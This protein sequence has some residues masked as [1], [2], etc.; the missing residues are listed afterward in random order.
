MKI[1]VSIPPG[2]IID[3]TTYEVGQSAWADGDK[4]R[5]WRGEPQTIGGWERI[6]TYR[7][8]G[9]CRNAFPWTDNSATLNIAF[10]THSHLQV[11]YGGVLFDIT[12][13][14]LA[15]GAVDGTGGAGYGTGVYSAGLYGEPST[16]I[17][18]PRTW[19]LSAYGQSLIANPRGA[20]IYQWNNVTGTP[21]A[22]VANAPTNV[23]AA[24]VTYTRQI[25]AFGCNEEISGVFNPLCIRYS[26]IGLPTVWNTDPGNEAREYI[27]DSGGRIVSAR[28][29][30]KYFFIWT[31]SD[32]FLASYDGSNA[33]QPWS[34]DR[35]GEKC[36]LVGP[37]AAVVLNQKAFWFT[38]AGQ[39]YACTLG[40]EP[41]LIVSPLAADLFENITTSQADKM[42]MSSC[43]EFAEI[44]LDYPDQ[45]DDI[46]AA[47][48]QVA[49][50]TGY[51]F[52]IA[53]DVDDTIGL[54]TALPIQPG[55][56]NSRYVAFCTVAN[57]DGSVPWA[58]GMMN[59]TAYVDAGAAPY[60]I[61]VDYF[62]AAYYQERGQSADGAPFAAFVQSADMYLGSDAERY[63]QVRGMW[64]DV[65]GQVGAMSLTVLTRQYPQGPVG[66][67]GPMALSPGL[68]RKDFQTT[69]RIVAVRYSSESGPT[70]WRLGKPVYDAIPTGVR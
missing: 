57:S 47:N 18:F 13:A 53:V 42:V 69:G 30:G 68:S 58:R 3:D 12:P 20:G 45:R 33:N 56:E 29:I 67:K 14:G 8:S 15:P 50:D 25:M 5:F 55:I 34:F 26:D 54:G 64:P 9:V 4:V 40:G 19:S 16:D 62:G 61:G 46:S 27:L 21:A 6:V 22:I 2:I 43:A 70:F 59:R 11:F 31:D 39:F 23:T 24:L 52:A 51:S 41:T 65:K 1:P 7:L 32:L 60:P 38:P 10:G 17:L 48:Y 44:R 36:G 28:R 49:G 63:I 66:S 37:N 35:V